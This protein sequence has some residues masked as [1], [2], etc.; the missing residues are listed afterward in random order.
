MLRWD[1]KMAEIYKCRAPSRSDSN[2]SV[3]QNIMFPTN[4]IRMIV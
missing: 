4:E 1:V 2:K 3:S